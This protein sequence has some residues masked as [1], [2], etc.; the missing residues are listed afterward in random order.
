VKLGLQ[1]SSFTWPGGDAEIAPTLARIVRTADEA[2]FD[3]IWVMDHFFQIRGNGPPE[4]PMLEGFTTL[5]YLAALTQRARL[6]LMVGGIHYRQPALWLKA[7]TTLDVLTGGRSYFGIGAAWNQE[8]SDALGFPFPELR[9]RFRMLEDTLRFVRDGWWGERGTEEAFAGR[10][11]QATHVLNSPQALSRPRPPILIGGGGELKTLRLVAQYADACNIFGN[12]QNL[13]RKYEILEEHCIDV[14]RDYAEIEKT[15]LSGI[16]ITE[17]GA[18]GSLTPAGF[19]DRL[20]AWAEAGSMHTIFSLRDVWDTSKLELIG[21]E[22]IPQ[23]RDMGSA[24]PI[25]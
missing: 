10:T 18:R 12:P 6:G 13:R 11:V 17:D 21:R 3:S 1:I 9:V 25:S 7:A 22:V 16:S 14:G 23:V 20:G 15:N 24:S 5:G 2:G 4:E 19:V 8:E